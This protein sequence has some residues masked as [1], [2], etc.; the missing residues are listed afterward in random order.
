MGIKNWIRN[1]SLNFNKK[2][3]DKVTILWI[4]VLVKKNG[5]I[6]TFAESHK[7]FDKS[8]LNLSWLEFYFNWSFRILKIERKPR[9]LW[10]PWKHWAQLTTSSDPWWRSDE[11]SFSTCILKRAVLQSSKD[12][13]GPEWA[14]DGTQY[15][16][17]L[18]DIWWLIEA[19]KTRHWL[20]ICPSF[21][22]PN[23]I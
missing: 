11:R 10:V 18:E 12:E 6:I 23:P 15:V 5:I 2:G 20:S 3:S 14:W 19:L 21:S 17:L 16:P 13:K 9:K 1:L 22:N 4:Q 7:P 8:C